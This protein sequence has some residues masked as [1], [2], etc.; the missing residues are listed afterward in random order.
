MSDITFLSFNIS[1]FRN[2]SKP[3]IEPTNYD[4]KRIYYA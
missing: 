3:L 4:S 2:Q 1:I